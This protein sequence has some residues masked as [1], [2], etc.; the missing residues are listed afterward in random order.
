MIKY[1]PGQ[2]DA[3][4]VYGDHPLVTA[5]DGRLVVYSFKNDANVRLIAFAPERR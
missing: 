4:A 2:R 1:T 5:G 3:T